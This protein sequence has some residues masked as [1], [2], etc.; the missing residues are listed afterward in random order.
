MYLAPSEIN[1]LRTAERVRGGTK[2]NQS[3]INFRTSRIAAEAAD[4]DP[5]CGSAL[6]VGE[7]HIRHYPGCL[8]RSVCVSGLETRQHIAGPIWSL[9]RRVVPRDASEHRATIRSMAGRRGV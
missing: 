3:M 2:L 8:H 6:C 7:R 5:L 9:C 4:S 1:I